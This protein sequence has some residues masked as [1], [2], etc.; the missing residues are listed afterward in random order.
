MFRFVVAKLVFVMLFSKM[1]ISCFYVRILTFT[2]NVSLL[3]LSSCLFQHFVSENQCC[4]K[5]K[6]IY[7][8]ERIGLT[9]YIN[10]FRGMLK[11]F[12]R[13]GMRPVECG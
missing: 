12:C 11:Q 8:D 1:G 13:L 3:L 6:I 10:M 5:N 2:S 9:I 7:G 4:D